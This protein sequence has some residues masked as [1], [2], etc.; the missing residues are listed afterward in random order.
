MSK[1]ASARIN[2]SSHSVDRPS[3]RARSTIALERFPI[4][5]DIEAVSCQPFDALEVAKGEAGDRTDLG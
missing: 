1:G 4:D 3:A 5:L 2:A